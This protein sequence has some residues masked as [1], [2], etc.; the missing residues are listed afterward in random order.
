MAVSTHVC[1]ISSHFFIIF[2]HSVPYL[3]HLGPFRPTFV[4]LITVTTHF[5]LFVPYF[6]HLRPLQ[7][8]FLSHDCIC[9][10]FSATLCH[11]LGHLVPFRP[12][13]VP[14]YHIFATFLPFRAIFGAFST[15][16]THIGAPLALLLLHSCHLEPYLE[17][18]GPYLGHLGP[19]RPTFVPYHH[20]HCRIPAIY[21]HIWGI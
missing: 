19:F 20:F 17:H 4:H 6:S 1:A 16:S 8:T 21:C 9:A 15:I 11:I 18:L 13:L 7:L 5:C 2:C 10:P 3:G 12:T 14:Y